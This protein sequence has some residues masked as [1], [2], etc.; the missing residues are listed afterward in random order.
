M[1]INMSI[2]TIIANIAETHCLSK[3]KTRRVFNAIVEAIASGAKTGSV[4]VPKLGT[5]KTVNRNARVC[6]NPKTGDTVDV[7]AK[8]LLKFK[9]HKSR[10]VP[11][12]EPVVVPQ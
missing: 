1:E 12:P 11:Q 9:P 6:R 8:A 4:V 2:Q 10:I 5:F 3:A 7:P